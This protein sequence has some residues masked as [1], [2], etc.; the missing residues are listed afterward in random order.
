MG[1]VRHKVWAGMLRHE[2]RCLTNPLFASV[3]WVI[4]LI[5]PSVNPTLCY[6]DHANFCCVSDLIFSQIR[7][8]A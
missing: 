5:F 7:A 1:K 2:S 6:G 4:T 3:L 8:F